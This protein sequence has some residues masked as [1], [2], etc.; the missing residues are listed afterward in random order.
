MPSRPAR[1]ARWSLLVLTLAGAALFARG[2][3]PVKPL[4]QGYSH[5]QTYADNGVVPP[6][7]ADPA[8]APFSR[9]AFVVVDALRSDFLLGPDSHMSF[10]ASLISSGRALP[11]TAIAQ[12]P[13]VTLPRLKALTTGSNPTFLDAIL[14]IAEESLSSAA[15]ENVDSWFRQL[16]LH[17]GQGEEKKKVV[18]AGDDTWLRL[19]PAEWFAWSEGVSSFFVSD[20][21]TV[22]TNVTRHLDPLLGTVSST[23]TSALPP[24]DWDALILHYLGLDHVGHLGGPS[25]P[26]MPPKQREMDDVL[27]RLYNHLEERDRADGKR[28]L[29]VVVGDHGMTEGGNHGGSTEAETSAA[30]LLASPSSPP[31]QLW[32]RIDHDSPYRHYEVV[33]QI[34][35]VPTLSVLFDLGIPRNSM[36]KLIPS[37][38]RALHPSAFKSALKA[39]VQQL[40]AVL[41]AS[42]A[43]ATTELLCRAGAEVGEGCKG[44]IAEQT[45]EVLLRFLSLAQSLLLST[46]STYSLPPLLLGISLLAL[47]SLLSLLTLRP[48]LARERPGVTLAVGGALVAYLGSFFASSFVEEEHEVW[49]FLGATGAVLLMLRP[50]LDLLDRALLFLTA[51]SIRLLRS[52]AH[53]GQKNLPNLSLSHSLSTSHPSLSS[54]LLLATYTFFLLASFHALLRAARS[55]ARRGLPPAALLKQALLLAVLATLAVAQVVL[56]LAVHALSAPEGPAAGEWHAGM[57]SA[58]EKL[59]VADKTAVARAGY[60]VGAVGWAVSRL[61]KRRAEEPKLR[62][63]Y[64]TLLLLNPLILLL[65][66]TRPSSA[67][68]FALSFWVQHLALARLARKGVLSPLGVAAWTVVAQESGFFG[69]GG[70]NSLASVDLSSS[71]TGLSSYSLPPVAL[72]TYLSNFSLP[73]LSSLSLSTLLSAAPASSRALIRTYLTAFYAASLAA[74]CASAGWFREHLFVGTVF[75][76][77][78]LYRGV[79]LVWVE[80]GTN[81]VLAPALIG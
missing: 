80:V 66:L 67:P 37:A 78:V 11:Y 25:S 77:A 20:T 55:F 16:A 47:S 69:L 68:L 39:N 81:L 6:D 42:A 71:Y 38:L 79:W 74:M 61:A 54:A 15:F 72:L 41:D 17:G 73:L 63:A 3:F 10:A 5:A 53:N 9:L 49:Y 59:E 56:G 48:F 19:F 40:S 64:S 31:T 14:N 24:N 51:G 2:F 22:D 58:L 45:E 62:E 75:A 43:G 18:F 65:S 23:A 27:Q 50:N 76:P 35:L 32:E 44:G 46:T 34:D 36:G 28:S 33:Q 60:G 1:P 70:S 30:L 26:L 7:A 29:L 12:S 4:L 57:V 8:S 52:W 21:V 13:T